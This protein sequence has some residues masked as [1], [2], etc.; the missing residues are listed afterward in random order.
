LRRSQ[1]AFAL[2]LFSLLAGCGQV[3]TTPEP[4]F[5]RAAGSTTLGPLLVQLAAAFGE[6]EPAVSIDVTAAGS[7]FGLDS[8]RAGEAELAFVSWLP[9]DRAAS[10]LEP[11]WRPTMIARDGVAVIVHPSNPVS[12][13]GL[14]QLRDLFGGKGYD[15]SALGGMARPG[16]VQPVSRE[17]G[18]GTRAAFEALA[19]EGQRVTPRA[20]VATSA[21]EVLQ[22]V[23]T[24]PEAI[25]YLSAALANE[26]VKVLTLEGE[27]PTPEAVQRGSYP[28][29]RELWL[30]T[31]STTSPALRRFLSFCLS[32]A[33]Q[34]IVR[35]EYVSLR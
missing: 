9:A 4:V 34:E 29:S 6:Q 12:G 10:P 32:P 15:W 14:L 2:L 18:S 22:Y 17:E 8:L 5:L 13:V 11:N 27:G 35:R 26:R 21:D 25:G 16:T 7:Q 24:H 30:V 23:A 1:R 3:V 31:G 19:M 28:L 33:G 20:V